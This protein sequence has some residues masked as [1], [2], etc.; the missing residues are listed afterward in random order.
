MAISPRRRSW[1]RRPT[2]TDQAVR[3]A[4][5]QVALDIDDPNGTRQRLGKAVR[6]A[7]SQGAELVVLPE[8]A[9]SGTC[10]RTTAE[11]QAAAQPVDGRF[12]GP[13]LYRFSDHPGRGR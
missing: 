6:Q 5:C 2:T 10:F 4:A 12:V 1:E 7:V 9:S 3:V 13:E 11:A 8:L